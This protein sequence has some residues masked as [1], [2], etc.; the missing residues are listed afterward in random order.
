MKH[1]PLLEVDDTFIN[2]DHVAYME[3][4]SETVTRISFTN[5]E[6]TLVTAP[7]DNIIS[8]IRG[9]TRAENDQ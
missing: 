7:L 8:S 9:A 2:M 1:R 3:V 6:S 4:H 5:G